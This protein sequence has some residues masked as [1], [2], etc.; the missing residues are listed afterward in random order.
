MA[1]K[2]GTSVVR[3]RNV[4]ARY[5][6]REREIMAELRAAGAPA[7]ELWLLHLAK[8]ELDASF[9]EPTEDELWD[10]A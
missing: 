1:S 8:A 5:T 3:W 2:Q 10:A 4:E 6:A 7:R 9:V